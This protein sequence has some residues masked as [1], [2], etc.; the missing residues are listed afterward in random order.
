M[1]FTSECVCHRP[2]QNIYPIFLYIPT[3]AVGL[4]RP[5]TT[6]I[7]WYTEDFGSMAK[8]V[9]NAK[10]NIYLDFSMLPIIHPWPLVKLLPAPYL[11]FSGH[12]PFLL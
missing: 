9:C 4:L 3:S 1:E 10:F 12:F 6:I 11:S 5:L 7:S 2:P 8:F